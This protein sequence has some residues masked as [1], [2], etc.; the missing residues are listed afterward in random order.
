MGVG[1]C[2]VC[3]CKVTLSG[4]WVTQSRSVL[5]HVVFVTIVPLIPTN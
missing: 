2:R 5:D 3:E 1:M 4:G